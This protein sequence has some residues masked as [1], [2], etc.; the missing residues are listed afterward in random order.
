MHPPDC[1]RCGA[2]CCN[3]QENRLEGYRDY[4]AVTPR[5]RALWS[6]PHLLRRYTVT[7]DRGEVHMKLVGEEQRCAALL[8][9]VGRRVECAIYAQRPRGCRRVEPG[10]KRCMQDRAEREIGS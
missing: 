9:S 3:P 7:N 2:C 4:I 8:G 5:D 6:R 10:D 1:L